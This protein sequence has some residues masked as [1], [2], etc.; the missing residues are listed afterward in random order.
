MAAL[1]GR[2]EAVRRFNRFYTQKIGVLDEGLLHSPYSL[3]EVR[4]LYELA[5]RDRPVAAG[6]GK[7]L[8]LD[9]GSLS[10]IL[11]GFRAK[12]IV[13]RRPS[14]SD[15]RQSVLSL[16]ARGR[17]ALAPLEARASEEIAALLKRLPEPRQIR[18]VGAMRIIES[19]LGPVAGSQA[20]YL[21]RQHQPGDMGWVVQ[22]HGELYAEEYGWNERFEALVAAI[23]ARFV[24]RFDPRRE[25]CWIA[26]RDG[27]RLGSVFLVKESGLTARLRML[28]VEPEARGPGIGSRLVDE[29]IRF[30]RQ[31]G[32]RGI[33]LWTQSILLAARKIYRRAG[34]RV[35]REEPE[36]HGF[37]KNLIAET[38]ELKL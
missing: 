15:G 17:R 28:L 38:W 8:G 11:R 35:L 16:T 18:L 7:G 19:V 5:H 10:R 14:D 2:V 3:T 32:Y 23:V 36:H 34:F 37:G 22:R 31:A 1:D 29:C 24:E 26:E 9:A 25:R 6:L 27:V 12:G 20:P 30:A 33:R 13:D 4:V 21:L